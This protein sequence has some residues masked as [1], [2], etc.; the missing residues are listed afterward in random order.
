MK[1]LEKE[2]TRLE[3]E[4]NGMRS[5]LDYLKDQNSFLHGE[6]ARL[7]ISLHQSKVLM[8]SSTL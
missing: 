6:V 8:A 3:T 4:V 7:E 1:F 2:N 5:E